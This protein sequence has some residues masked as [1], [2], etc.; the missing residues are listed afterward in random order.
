MARAVPRL[1]LALT[2]LATVVVDR[3]A[4][5]AA[6]RLLSGRAP[7]EWLGGLVRFSLVENRGAF[8]SAGGRLSEGTRFTLLVAGVGLGLFAALALLLAQRTL[9]ARRSFAGAVMLGGGLA[10][11]LD[12]LSDGTVTDFLVL[13]AGPLHTGVFNLADAAIVAGA[14][15]FC[16]PARPP[17]SPEKGPP[18]GGATGT[19][20]RPSSMPDSPR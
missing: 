13:A 7:V 3:L 15:G 19:G 14:L 4:K 6:T 2:I 1:A 16:F 18:P 12:R 10:N 9:P 11:W 8:L 17:N 20:A 5:E